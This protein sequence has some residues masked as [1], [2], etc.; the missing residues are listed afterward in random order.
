MDPPAKAPKDFPHP[1]HHR[2]RERI[3]VPVPPDFSI[4]SSPEERKKAGGEVATAH[5]AMFC[6]GGEIV[7]ENGAGLPVGYCVKC[8]RLASQVVSCVLR[9]RKQPMTWFGNR[10]RIEAGLCRKHREDH[11]IAVALT[12]SMLGVAAVLVVS[13][14]FTSHP[15]TLVLAGVVA[16]VSGAFR[17]GSPVSAP[18]AS[19][20][21]V[22]LSDAGKA[23]L[24]RLPAFPESGEGADPEIRS[25]PLS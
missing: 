1:S 7:L 23:F 10:P 21:R 13:G 16:A 2:V 6:L 5:P 4:Q 12:W 14:I 9:D 3:I 19:E 18:V 20:S 25:A 8:G 11:A 22:V 15:V 24:R 17:A